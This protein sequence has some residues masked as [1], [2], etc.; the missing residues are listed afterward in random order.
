MFGTKIGVFSRNYGDTLLNSLVRR[1]NK[2][3]VPKISKISLV[4]GPLEQQGCPRWHMS[5]L[6]SAAFSAPT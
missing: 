5:E 2:Y 4:A 6:S 3:G 1:T